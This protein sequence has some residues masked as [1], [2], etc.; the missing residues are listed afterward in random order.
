MAEGSGEVGPV[1]DGPWGATGPGSEPP[2]PPELL[3]HELPISSRASSSGRDA[4][5]M[6]FPYLTEH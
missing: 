6:E 2:P 3:L 4:F 1:M 5:F